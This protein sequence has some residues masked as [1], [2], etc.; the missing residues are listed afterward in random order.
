[1]AIARITYSG[2]IILII[3]FTTFTITVTII[4]VYT[5]TF[6]FRNAGINIIIVFV[7]VITSINVV[8]IE[9]VFNIIINN[10]FIDYTKK[11]YIDNNYNI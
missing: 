10:S 4:A 11:L 2:P 3:T 6:S 5:V 1:M 9:A 8:F 7:G